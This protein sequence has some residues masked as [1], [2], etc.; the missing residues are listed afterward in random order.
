MKKQK[1]PECSSETETLSYFSECDEQEMERRSRATLREIASVLQRMKD[2]R[3]SHPDALPKEVQSE[4]KKRFVEVLLESLLVEDR[5]ELKRSVVRR[6]ADKFGNYLLWNRIS[7]TPVVHEM[8]ALLPWWVSH[9]PGSAVSSLRD[10]GLSYFLNGIVVPVQNVWKEVLEARLVYLGHCVCRSSG[11][12][13]DLYQDGKIVTLLSRQDNKRL[14]NRFMDRYRSLKIDGRI[15]DTDPRYIELCE[16]LDGLR[17]KGSTRYCLE[18]LLE[19]L[20][21]DW[22]ILPVHEKYTP[23]WIRSM[24]ANRKA[25]S[26]HKELVF[27]LATI[28]YLSR[29]VIFTSMRLVDTPYTICSCPTPETGGGCVLTNWYYWG[30][31]NASLLPNEHAFGRRKNQEGNIMPCQFFP[32][33]GR[34][35]CLGCGCRHGSPHP[36]HIESFLSEADGIYRAYRKKRSKNREGRSS[37]G[38]I[39]G[40]VS[41]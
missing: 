24:H 12:V 21:P 36:R 10:I 19:D 18:T 14:L 9:M 15:P 27:E 13:D 3:V 6:M 33:R 22:E 28:L 39:S 11:I 23:D 29:G 32:V 17:R 4:N 38:K 37:P 31:S 5:P 7:S 16:R 40:G 26:I 2:I 1:A 20:Y 35:E 25:H 30:M 41:D 8:A 34:R